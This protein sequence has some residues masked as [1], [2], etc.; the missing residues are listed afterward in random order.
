MIQVKSEV[1]QSA[2]VQLSILLCHRQTFI[3]KTTAA[4]L[5]ETLLIYGDCAEFKTENLDEVMQILSSTN[6][7]ESIETVKPI[8]NQLCVL[9]GVRVPVPKVQAS[10]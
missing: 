10:K 7:E 2:L 3:R 8:R 5:Y 9:M 4:V 1:C 6:W